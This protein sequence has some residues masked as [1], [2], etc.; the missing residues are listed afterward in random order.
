[1]ATVSPFP[2]PRPYAF[3]SGC[4]RKREAF[5][6]LVLQVVTGFRPSPER[7]SVNPGA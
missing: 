1:M 6:V 3:G 5:L 2:E 4:L 7:L